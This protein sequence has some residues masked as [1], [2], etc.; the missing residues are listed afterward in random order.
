[1][2]VISPSFVR[3]HPSFVEPGIILQY[4]QASNAFDLL[5]SGGPEAKLGEGDLYVYMKRADI[6]TR[7]AAGQAAANQLPSISIAMSQIS[8]PTYLL[9]VRGEFD[10]HDT[11]ALA[12]WGMGMMEAQRLG[13]R[14]GHFQ[15]ARNGLLYGFNSVNGEGLLNTANASAS[16]LPPDSN[17]NNT[18]VTYDNGELAFFFLTLMAAIKTR[19]YQFGIGRKFTIIGPQ[20]DLGLMEMVNIV[21]LVQFQRVGAGS[22]TSAQLVKAVM[23][24][25]GDTID[26]GY[27]DTLIGKG[28]AG[29]DAIVIAMT[30][31]EKPT[32]SRWNTNEWAKIAPGLEACTAMY[33]DKAAPTEIPTPLPGGATDLVSEFR[34][35]P[36][37]GIRPEAITV[38]SVQYE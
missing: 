14:Q 13:A 33:C 4:S 23:G 34:I 30:E 18:M 2:P 12:N 11:A 22:A 31:V 35:S 20:R 28:A 25:N 26:W 3:V 15:L 1:M 37:W 9:R 29:T 7:A 38:L 10:H 16:G 27:D 24:M 8:I 32:N 21:Q 36:G 19:T 17:G 5:P 6:R